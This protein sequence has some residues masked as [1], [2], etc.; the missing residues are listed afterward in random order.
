MLGL[1]CL[2]RRPM[3]TIVMIDE[4]SREEQIPKSFAAKIFQSLVRAGL[5]RSARGTGGGFTLLR[6]PAEI[7]VLDVIEA[8]EGKIALQRCLAEPA[9]CDHTGGCAL[10]GL[11]EQAQDRVKE[12]FSRTTLADLQKKHSPVGDAHRMGA[13][14]NRPVELKP[15]L[16]SDL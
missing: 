9:A 7:T 6:S 14:S 3:G 5:V 16:K 8:I 15:E 4:V 12:V 11:F 10:C 1:I 13:R 2:A